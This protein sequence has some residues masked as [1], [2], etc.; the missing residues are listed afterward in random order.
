V[1]KG[2]KI[3][4]ISTEDKAQY[5]RD[6]NNAR[7]CA[8]K[9][10]DSKLR[11]AYGISLEDYTEML[12]EQ[13]GCCAICRRHHSLF[14]RKLSVDHDHKTGAVRGLLCK[15]CNTS[16]GQF[17]DDVDTLLTAISYLNKYK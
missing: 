9:N 3:L 8:D 1:P 5:K 6:Y 14:R 12:S 16:L 2:H 15:D 13:D 11:K 17:N 4:Y 7:Y 10:R